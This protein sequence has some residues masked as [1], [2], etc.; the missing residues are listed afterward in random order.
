M[1]KRKQFKIPGEIY[2][3]FRRQAPR[4]RLSFPK[5]SFAPTKP[6]PAKKP[7][8]LNMN[9]QQAFRHHNLPPFGDID[10]DKRINMFDCRPFDPRRQHLSNVEKEKLRK[11]EIT[12]K[13]IEQRKKELAEKNP[14]SASD[15]Y[16]KP[17]STEHPTD[18][19]PLV[20]DVVDV[21]Y[22][23]GYT[24]AGS[25]QGGKGHSVYP[26][27][28]IQNDRNLIVAFMRAGFEATRYASQSGYVA[29]EYQ[30]SLTNQQRKNLWERAL[31]EVQKL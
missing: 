27:I 29:M 3:N 28:D 8:V 13:A 4:P 25:C 20:Q 26:S 23:K 24:T 5:Y 10:H 1:K 6:A 11:I 22:Q 15:I 31:K 16:F 21:I 19:D 12:Y 18:L 17:Y 9:Y 30:K 14:E 2:T 7:K